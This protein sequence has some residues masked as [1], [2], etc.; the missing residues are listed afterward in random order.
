MERRGHEIAIANVLRLEQ[1]IGVRLPD[2]YRQFLLEVNGGRTTDAHREFM[3][4]KG[5][6]IGQVTLDLLHSLDDQSDDGFELR[7]QQLFRRYDYPENGLRIGYASGWALVLILSGPHRG[8]LWILAIQDPPIEAD[9]R[10]EWFDR[11]DAWKVAD[12]FAEFMA[13]LRPS[14]AGA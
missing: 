2:D 1:E 11:P 5:E 14:D 13:G 10:I 4:R 7:E 6:Q 12:S 3:M 9:Q 8:E